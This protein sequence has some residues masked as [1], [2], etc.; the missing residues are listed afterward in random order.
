MNALW[1]IP[2]VLGMHI[3]GSCVLAAFVLGPSLTYGGLVLAVFAWFFVP[4][5]TIGAFTIYKFYNPTLDQKTKKT[6]Q[7]AFIVGLTGAFIF[8]PFIPKEEGSQMIGW[9]GAA[10][11]GCSSAVFA[12]ICVHLLK[13]KAIKKHA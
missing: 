11:A 9:L 3:F 12:F 10:F 5:E 4:F 8:A 13:L 7:I 6:L 2:I 1:L